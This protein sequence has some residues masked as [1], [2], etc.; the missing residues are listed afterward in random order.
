MAHM[1]F[2]AIRKHKMILLHSAV[3]NAI[4]ICNPEAILW[5][6]PSPTFPNVTKVRFNLSGSM[7]RYLNVRETPKEIAS[8]AD[9]HICSKT[10]GD[11]PTS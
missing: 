1:K 11:C 8:L 10:S 6:A 2:P 9:W 3:D 5:V 7:T 4:I